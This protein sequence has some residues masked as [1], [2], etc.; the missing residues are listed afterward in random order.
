MASQVTEDV[1]KKQIVTFYV[2]KMDNLQG[3]LELRNGNN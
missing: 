1:I 3:A 2:N